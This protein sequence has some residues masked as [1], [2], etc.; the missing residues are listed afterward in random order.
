M[1]CFV[2][3]VDAQAAAHLMMQSSGQLMLHGKTCLMQWARSRPVPRDLYNAI[4]MGA[5]RNLFV[6]N[7]P[8]DA[9]EASV[10]ALFAPF[11]ELESVRLAPKKEAAF[12]NFSSIA[13]GIKAKDM[14]QFKHWIS[15]DANGVTAETGASNTTR[16]PPGFGS[17][18]AL[19]GVCR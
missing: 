6:A 2:N 10:G 7:V 11:G 13:A 3:F 18:N 19:T 12:V 4:R 14:M 17:T 16:A 1:Q 9:T 15:R 5:T 8:P